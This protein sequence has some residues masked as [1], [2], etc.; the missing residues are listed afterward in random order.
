MSVVYK[1]TEL[2][3]I[4]NDWDFVEFSSIAEL[5]HGY[6]FRNYDFTESGIKILKITQIKGNETIDISSCS[7]ISEDRIDDFRRVII[8][9]GDILIALTGATIGKI[10]RFNS[11]E[12][13]LQNYRVGNFFPLDKNKLSKDYLFHYLRSNFFYHQ[14]LARQTQSAQQNIGKEE[15][16]NMM[17][18]LPKPKEQTSIAKILTAFD[19]KIE[20]LQAQNKTLEQTTQTIFKEW[21]GK[22]KVGD[23]LPDGWIVG[24]I[25]DVLDVQYGFPFKSKLF[26]EDKKGL[27]LIR[28]RDIRK[29]IT[30]YFTDEEYLNEYIV[31]SGDVLA[32]MDAVFR[33]YLWSGQKGLLN[34]RVCRFI[35]K[36]FASRIFVFEFMKPH[37]SFYEKTKVGTTVIHLGKSD[38]DSIVTIIPSKEIISK[39]KELSTP[40]EEK[41]INN[42]Q[43]IQTLKKTRDTLLP[44][45]MSGQIRVNEF[46]G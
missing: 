7:Y 27:P 16:N 13:V 34:Q 4:P 43:K 6:Q 5:R 18:F 40:I 2:G 1:E 35:P 41:I 39:F 24:K 11:D 44:K 36:K 32:G 37:L 8:N 28:I 23:E 22:Y 26:N 42:N 30:G 19:D 10:A 15:I 17:V 45:L 21:F 31:N 33:P 12:L 38:L 20:N 46:K 3:K 9:K 14:I 25:Y 29:G